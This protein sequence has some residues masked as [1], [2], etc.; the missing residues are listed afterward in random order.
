MQLTRPL[1]LFSLLLTCQIG[2][3]G[4]FSQIGSSRWV[5]VAKVYDG[6]TFKT[7]RG[8]KVRLLGI[9]TPE[10]PHASKAG[11]PLGKKATKHLKALIQGQL[12]RL[13]FDQVKRDKYGRLL[14]HVR[15]RDGSWIN[16]QMIKDGMAHLYIFAPNF[17]HAGKLLEHEKK[18]RLRRSGIWGNSRFKIVE[19]ALVTPSMIG[20]FRL[21]KGAVTSI[22]KNGWKFK[23]GKLSISIPRAYR[24]WFKSTP[25][26]KPGQQVVVRG[27][28][29]ISQKE[30]LFLA[31]HSPFDLE[32]IEQ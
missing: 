32:K 17:R 25:K 24:A 9:N 16:S 8:E 13:E 1:L 6:D 26:L 11:E 31:L 12:V 30:R 7:A 2:W 18:A 28:I 5:T 27:K 10:I 14:A 4:T 23:M 29:R 20:Q 15:L 21:V 3:A 22:D 19:H